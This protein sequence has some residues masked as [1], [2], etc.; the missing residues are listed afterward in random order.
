MSEAGIYPISTLID[1][2]GVG[3]DNFNC[4]PVTCKDSKEK[5]DY[6]D[7]NQFLLNDALK[8]DI[9]Q[10][11]KTFLY[12][13]NNR[14]IG[15]FTTSASLSTIKKEYRKEKGITFNGLS[16]YPTINI[17]Y[18]A[19]D[20]NFQGSGYGKMLM[21]F[22]LTMIYENVAQYTGVSLVTVEALAG[23]KSFYMD[24]FKF[25]S[26]ASKNNKGKQDVALTIPEIEQL[27]E[28]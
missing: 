18:F 9:E 15:F 20:K 26:H 22:V 5:Q 19:I 8:F 23:A 17:S 11:A 16:E 24:N 10:L 28:K 21:K 6:E 12:L 7:I 3:L 4:I 2:K 14:V 13:E 27:L 1:L 25:E